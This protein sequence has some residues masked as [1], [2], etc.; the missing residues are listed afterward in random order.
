MK[1]KNVAPKDLDKVKDR[2]FCLLLYP[3]ADDYPCKK[4][5]NYL[6][7]NYEIAYILHD[8]DKWTGDD[9]SE[10]ASHKAGELKKPHYHVVLRW[11]GASA[12]YRTGLAKEITQALKLERIFPKT[13][14]EPC[15]KLDGSLMYLIHYGE[16]EKYQYKMEKVKG[17]ERLM[18]LFYKLISTSE[19]GL[20]AGEMMEDIINWIDAYENRSILV[21]E[22]VRYCISCCYMDVYRKYSYSIHRMIDEHNAGVFAWMNSQGNPSV[23]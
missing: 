8:K 12:R 13:A 15:G 2:K 17:T 23:K 3:D 7:K 4:V 20:T 21:K 1:R 6:E 9:E 14:I 19:G 22:L 10:N 5:L 18:E 11:T 16:K